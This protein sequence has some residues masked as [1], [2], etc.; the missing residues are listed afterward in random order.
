MPYIDK[1]RRKIIYG[2]S[3][4]ITNPGE[5]NYGVTR[6]IDQYIHSQGGLNYTTLNAV[7]G[8]LECAKLEAYRKIGA[9]YEDRCCARNGEV[10]T[11]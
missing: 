4:H 2:S 11:L 10:Y 1:E 8:V 3:I 5:L 9:P 7:I 6:L